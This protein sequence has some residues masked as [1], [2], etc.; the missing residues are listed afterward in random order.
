MNIVQQLLSIIPLS[1]TKIAEELDVT[2]VTISNYKT[3]RTFPTQ[4][5][6]YDL[7]RLAEF[8]HSANEQVLIIAKHTGGYSNEYEY[9]DDITTRAS[10]L[11]EAGGGDTPR[12]AAAVGGAIASGKTARKGGKGK[13]R[14]CK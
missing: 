1:S 3:G 9:K 6:L 12:Q 8:V 5:K 11:I 13:G 4:K 2:A 7:Y 10:L 14:P